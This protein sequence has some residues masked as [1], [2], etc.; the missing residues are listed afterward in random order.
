MAKASSTIPKTRNNGLGIII[1]AG[2]NPKKYSECNV[3][4]PKYKNASNVAG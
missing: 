3:I 4:P 2:T 1:T